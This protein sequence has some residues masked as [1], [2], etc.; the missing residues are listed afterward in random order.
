MEN[1]CKSAEN[2]GKKQHTCT[3]V[4]IVCSFLLYFH[5]NPSLM[6]FIY[7]QR[8]HVNCVKRLQGNL[9]FIQEMTHF[10]AQKEFLRMRVERHT[11]VKC[12][13]ARLLSNL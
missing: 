13:H 7:Q 2:G 12:L 4:T 11:F 10:P 3:V 5:P 8:N 1:F 6:T 9:S